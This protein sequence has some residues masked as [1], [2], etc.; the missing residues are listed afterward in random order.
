M[1][2]DPYFALKDEVEL[3]VSNASKLFQNWNQSLNAA[4]SSSSADAFR[5]DTETLKETL[6]DIDEDLKALEET[7]D[8]LSFFPLDADRQA[9]P[10]KFRLDPREIAQRKNFIASTRRT[11]QIRLQDMKSQVTNPGILRNRA[12][13][14]TRETLFQTKKSVKTTDKYG[15]TE[16]EYRMSNARFIEREQQQQQLLMQRQD[17]QMDDVYDTVVGLKDVAAVMGNELEDQAG[18]LQDLE[19]NVD[20]TAGKLQLGLRRMQDFIKANAG[21]GI[22]VEQGHG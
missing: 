16:E 22:G 19:A 18:L 5:R 10:A 4:D 9:N 11:V 12:E 7:I 21:T 14:E 1:S 13:K 15:R 3:N 20:T 2:E 6:L 8:I 17:E